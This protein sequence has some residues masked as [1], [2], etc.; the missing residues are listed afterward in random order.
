[1]SSGPI[2]IKSLCFWELQMDHAD[3]QEMGDVLDMQKT[4]ANANFAKFIIRNYDSWLNDPKSDKP[5]LS[6]QMMKRKVFPE[7]G[8]KTSVRDSDRQPAL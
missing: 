4:E 7:L 5:L 2:S 8:K 3:N 1:M 6:H